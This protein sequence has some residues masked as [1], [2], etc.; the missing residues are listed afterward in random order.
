MADFTLNA[1]GTNENP[2]TPADII[3]PSGSLQ[4]DSTLG[5]R[6][7]S[8]AT[9]VVFAHDANYG[10]VITA[11]AVISQWHDFDELFV[12]AVVRTGGNA[13][14]SVG[15][16]ILAD[17]TLRFRR[18][19]AA[20]SA[21]DIG[22]DIIPPVTIT[23]AD[24]I[25]V[26]YNKTTG[27]ISATQ[28]GS[29]IGS[30]QTDSTYAGESSLAAGV[31][32]YP[33]GNNTTY[34]ASF[35]GTG[36]D[37][38]A[39]TGTGVLTATKATMS[40]SGTVIQPAT[41][42][43]ALTA[44]KATTSGSGLVMQEIVASGIITDNRSL[45]FNLDFTPVD[46]DS[47]WVPTIWEGSTITVAADGTFV[48]NPA[49]PDGT[50]LPRWSYDV[51]TTTRYEDEITINDNGSITITGSGSLVA[52]KGVVAGLGTVIPTESSVG[53]GALVASK[54][55]I[56][57]SGGAQQNVTGSGALS[58][59]K[60]RVKGLGGVNGVFPG[61]GDGDDGFIHAIK[62]ALIRLLRRALRK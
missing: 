6:N 46:G 27:A 52:S 12:G 2:W 42:T 59:R 22:G 45:F 13:G 41:G 37:G 5:I 10:D 16:I 34:I 17:D 44:T 43:G 20:G 60:P 33:G 58:S 28:N 40:G 4:T 23:A 31:Y 51:S 54:A 36:V 29:T 55:T 35:S 49:L 62:R 18:I 24:V 3:I 47:V 25:E 39:V 26:V 48:I 53:S 50:V 7:G 11:E 57:G 56:S 61:G 1:P 8:G 21:T 9:H 19:N 14:A 15:L 30:G 32:M 38:G